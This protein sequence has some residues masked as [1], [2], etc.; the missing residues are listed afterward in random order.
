MQNEQGADG[1]NN[2][3][4]WNLQVSIFWLVLQLYIV[5]KFKEIKARI[6]IV[7]HLSYVFV[8]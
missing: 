5:V 7:Q 8:L 6:V 2:K 4:N 1:R 3:D